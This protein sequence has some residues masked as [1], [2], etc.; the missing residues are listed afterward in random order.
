MYVLLALSVH[1]E[2][3]DVLAMFVVVM[4]LMFTVFA[5]FAAH[6]ASVMRRLRE[7]PAPRPPKRHLV[8]ALLRS[9]RRS[10]DG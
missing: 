2:T 3:S 8:R 9:F 5:L 7:T 10:S 4:V 6:V 1:E